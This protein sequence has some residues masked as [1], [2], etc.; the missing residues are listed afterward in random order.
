MVCSPSSKVT[1][2]TED[3]ISALWSLG[4]SNAT[5]K[6]SLKDKI[7]GTGFAIIFNCSTWKVAI[8]HVKPWF[9]LISVISEQIENTRVKG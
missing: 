1:T 5:S 9:Y 2:S 4:V 8:F 7:S 6:K 3:R